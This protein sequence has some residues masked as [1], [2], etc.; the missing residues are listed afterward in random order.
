MS[1]SVEF[2]HSVTTH[3][4]KKGQDVY[5][6]HAE[7]GYSKDVDVLAKMTDTGNGYLFKFPSYSSVVDDIHMAIGYSEVEYIAE[8]FEYAKAA[9][10][11]RFNRRWS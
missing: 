11:E 8:L 2:E 10:P 6:L 3:T 5:K 4:N 7:E 9:H 1:I